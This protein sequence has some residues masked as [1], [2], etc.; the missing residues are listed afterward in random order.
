VHVAGEKRYAGDG[1]SLI[2]KCQ[3]V[4]QDRVIWRYRA[5]GSNNIQVV[6]WR[7]QTYNKDRKRFRIH[8]LGEGVFDLAISSVKPTDAGVYQ[9]REIGGQHPGTTCTDLVVT[10]EISI[11]KAS[12]E[13]HTA[14]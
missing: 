4:L 5:Y 9:C 6:Y 10:G 11:C 7:N 14:K 2:L 12:A 3:A 13:L 1:Q 8:Q